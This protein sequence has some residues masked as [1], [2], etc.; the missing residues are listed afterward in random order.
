MAK[1]NQDLKYIY[2]ELNFSN[3]KTSAKHD[4]FYLYLYSDPD[5]PQLER[6]KRSILI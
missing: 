3:A 5:I 6:V 2:K 4:T 1:I